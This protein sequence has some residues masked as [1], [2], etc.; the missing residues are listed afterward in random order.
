[1]VTLFSPFSVQR[2]AVSTFNF[3]NNEGRAVVA[4]LLPY[5]DDEAAAAVGGNPA[6]GSNGTR[7]DTG[8]SANGSSEK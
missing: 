5:G 7:V 2:N 6:A 8:G 3:L 1:M 4:A